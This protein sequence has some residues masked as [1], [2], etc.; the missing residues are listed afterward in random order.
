MKDHKIIVGSVGM[1]SS[2]PSETLLVE[3]EITPTEVEEK[4]KTAVVNIFGNIPMEMQPKTNGSLLVAKA[5]NREPLESFR[6]VLRRDRVRA[7]ARKLLG[8]KIRGN[9][10]RFFLNKQVAF[11]GHISFSQE[12]GESPL[13]PIRVVIETDSP[14]EL[15]DWLAPRSA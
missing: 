9:T 5:R 6:A 4:V 3:A 14:R 10:I 15:V 8:P 11:T 1:A 7:A 13:G 2:G 12:V